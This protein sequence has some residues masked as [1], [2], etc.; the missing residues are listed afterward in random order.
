M[1]VGFSDEM[2]ILPNKLVASCQIS[3]FSPENSPILRSQTFKF[4][5]NAE[6]PVAIECLEQAAAQ[7]SEI[8]AQPAPSAFVLE[9]NES[10]KVVTTA[11]Q[12]LNKNNIPLAKPILK[13]ENS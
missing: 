3:N 7:I 2:I 10:F 5:H 6:I 8:K 13:L 4:P 1:L 9:T 11:L 12:L